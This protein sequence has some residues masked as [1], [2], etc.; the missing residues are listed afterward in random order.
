MALELHS[1]F[2]VADDW[3]VNLRFNWGLTE[4][5]RAEAMIDTANSIGK[6]T[7]GAYGTVWEWAV[8]KDKYWFPRFFGAFF[9]S[10]GLVVPLTV[11]GVFYVLSPVAP[12]TYLGCDITGSYHLGDDDLNAYVEAGLGLV[13]YIH[14]KYDGIYGGLGPTLGF[15]VKLGF[16]TVGV[17]GTWS[18]PGAHGEPT[19]GKSNVYVGGLTVTFGN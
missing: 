19:D 17:H 11:A 16:A 14:P 3:K 6:W 1:G 7:I 5:H 12:T 15:G 4:F 18:P 9:A 2:R 8:Q 10:I 13:S